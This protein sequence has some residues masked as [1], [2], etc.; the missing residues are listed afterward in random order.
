MQHWG[1]FSSF[2]HFVVALSIETEKEVDREK[3]ER[4]DF[5]S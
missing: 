1:R 2:L 4:P 5:D 3:H